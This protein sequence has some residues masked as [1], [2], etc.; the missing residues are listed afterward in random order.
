MQPDGERKE[1]APEDVQE[2][3][4]VA[5]N[6]LLLSLKQ[7]LRASGRLFLRP[8]HFVQ[9]G[10]VKI[11]DAG[12]GLLQR[13]RKSAAEP[14]AEEASA[15]ER[16]AAREESHARKPR[17]D[18]SKEAPP[19]QA[20]PKQA[21]AAHPHSPIHN[22]L[23]YLL[24]LI[25]G[26]LAGMTFSFVLFSTMVSN[27][28]Q[29]IDD[30]R[31]E[32]SQLEKQHSILLESEARYRKENNEYRKQL[33]EIEATAAARNAEAEKAAREAAGNSVAPQGAR[34]PVARKTG[35]C[36]LDAGNID[37]NLTRCVEEF[38]RK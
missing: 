37:N 26:G 1:G 8:K 15:D 32:I 19:K 24:V 30:Q 25:V 29:K 16:S 23:I 4:P 34:R 14:S 22:I 6:R 27:Q 18:H 21:V 13:L 11:I 20:P 5:G 38:N 33:S 2:D 17:E 9:A 3:I 10:V 35:N 31:D 12:T 7:F 28:A 36:N